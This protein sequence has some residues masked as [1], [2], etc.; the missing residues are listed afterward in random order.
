MACEFLALFILSKNAFCHLS[1]V[2]LCCF[3][4]L[5]CSF[6]ELTNIKWCV[7]EVVLFSSQCNMKFVLLDCGQ[8]QLWIISIKLCLH[9][10]ATLL[11]WLIKSGS[12][13]MVKL[14]VI[15]INSASL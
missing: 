4:C 2:L 13:C 15:G 8:C 3:V 9:L 6:F 11:K 10:Y 1:T 7:N 5:F 12:N 14:V